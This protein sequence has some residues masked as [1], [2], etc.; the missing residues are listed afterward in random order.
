MSTRIA[1]LFATLIIAGVILTPSMAGAGG[2]QLFFNPSPGWLGA[3]VTVSG[4]GLQA[5]DTYFVNVDGNQIGTGP[6]NT[7][8]AFSFQWVIPSNHPT[9]TLNTFMQ[10]GPAN[11]SFN[12]SY[13]VNASPP[14]TTTLPTTTTT[15]TTTTTT[16]TV[17]DTTTTEATTT[18]VPVTTTTAPSCVLTISPDPGQQGETVTVSGQN[19]APS[20]TFYVNLNGIQIGIGPTDSAGS[21]SFQYPI[22]D[23]HAIG[24]FNTFMQDD[25]AT[26][27]FNG[28]YTVEAGGGGGGNNTP[29]WWIAAVLAVAVILGGTYSLV[30]SR[31]G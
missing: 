17:P 10:D 21:F 7:N 3:S 18:T 23:S 19:L 26:C 12:G 31:R 14:T 15:S 4:T 22:P 20:D 16:T 1:R 25:P 24:T 27:S 8:G 28:S 30:T 2:C 13:T 11:C 29:L 9:G 5:N 6:T